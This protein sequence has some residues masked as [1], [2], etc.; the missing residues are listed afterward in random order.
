MEREKLKLPK[1]EALAILREDQADP[2]AYVIIED[3]LV[4]NKR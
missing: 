2:V 3:K 4:G 1:N